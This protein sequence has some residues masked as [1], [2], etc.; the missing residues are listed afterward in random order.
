L[1]AK[2]DDAQAANNPFLAGIAAREASMGVE[3]WP[4]NWPAFALFCSMQ[5]Q[6]RVGM[7]G[8]TGIDYSALYPLL[9]RH[10]SDPDEWNALF[11]DVQTCERAA[12][13][14]MNTKD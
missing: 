1:Y 13:A 14:A 8:A 4:E 3:V 9:D 11:E 2:N 6:W 7:G 5:T 12:L 10:A